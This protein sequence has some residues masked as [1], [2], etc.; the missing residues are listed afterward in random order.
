MPKDSLF[1]SIKIWNTV[2]SF[3]WTIF[4]QFSL[5]GTTTRQQLQ[6]LQGMV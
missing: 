6:H 3:A 4:K 2:G 1:Q 5:V